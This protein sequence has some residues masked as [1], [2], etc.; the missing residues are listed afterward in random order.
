MASCVTIELL[1]RFETVRADSPDDMGAG[2]VLVDVDGCS[3]KGGMKGNAKANGLCWTESDV[4]ELLFACAETEVKGRALPLE[5][6]T[7]SLLTFPET[8]VKG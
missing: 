8:E 4:P 7:G 2:S 1:S 6:V 5:A 3:C